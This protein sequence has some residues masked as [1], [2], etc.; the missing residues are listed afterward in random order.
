MINMNWIE[1]EEN[2]PVIDPSLESYFTDCTVEEMINTYHFETIAEMT[3]M[4]RTRFPA[5]FSEK[6][7]LEIAKTSFRCRAA[8]ERENIHVEEK[9]L[10]DFIY[11]F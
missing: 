3:E 2:F 1:R 10:V 9:G 8:K 6:E 5:F 4:I 11:P 7:I